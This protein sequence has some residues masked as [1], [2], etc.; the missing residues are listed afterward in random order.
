MNARQLFQIFDIFTE[1]LCRIFVETIITMD[2]MVWIYTAF[3]AIPRIKKERSRELKS[4]AGLIFA[5]ARV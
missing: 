3:Y 4:I 1:D 2:M 5:I